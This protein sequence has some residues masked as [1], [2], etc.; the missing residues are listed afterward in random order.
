M[1]SRTLSKPSLQRRYLRTLI[2]VGLASLWANFPLQ[3]RP[4]P[5]EPEGKVETDQVWHEGFESDRPTWIREEVDA[6]V[7][8]LT[9]DRSDQAAREGAKSERFVF[10][11]GPLKLLL[12][13]CSFLR[14]S[15]RKL[16][17]GRKLGSNLEIFAQV[18]IQSLN[19]NHGFFKL[20]NPLEKHLHGI[21]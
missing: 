15:R 16:G 4:Y 18:L 10:K 11:A 7:D 2:I 8:W 19:A 3:A 21:S 20:R 14:M 17:F 12:L 6:P 9:H 5:D 13:F 1:M